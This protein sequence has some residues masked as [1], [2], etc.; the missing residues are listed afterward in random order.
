MVII[1]WIF[2]ILGLLVIGG[3]IISIIFLSESQATVMQYIVAFSHGIS[4]LFIAS[5]TRYKD[6]CLD[7][8]LQTSY[9]SLVDIKLWVM[10]MIISSLI[11]SS[12][13]F[14]KNILA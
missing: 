7:E 10:I 5:T 9:A 6:E 4:Y 8:L 13:S 14:L 11:L 12:F 3:N 1:R 2:F